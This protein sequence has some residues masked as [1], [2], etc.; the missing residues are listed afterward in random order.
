MEIKVVSNSV[1][2]ISFLQKLLSKRK[3]F[4]L[5]IDNF[6]KVTDN[7]LKEVKVIISK[8]IGRQVIAFEYFGY[9]FVFK[10]LNAHKSKIP[11]ELFE[12]NMTTS[13]GKN[14]YES[15]TSASFQNDLIPSYY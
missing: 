11:N 2:V 9:E 7:S 8:E 4:L 13:P 3:T 5:T 15:Y 1:E 12:D 14:N 6:E 10:M